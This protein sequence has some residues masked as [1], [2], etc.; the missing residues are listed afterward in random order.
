MNEVRLRGGGLPFQGPEVRQ[1]FLHGHQERATCLADGRAYHDPGAALAYLSLMT[2]TT[3]GYGDVTPAWPGAGGLAAAEAIVG[4]LY[5]A[6]TIARLVGLH[7]G[8]DRRIARDLSRAK[9]DR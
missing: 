8:D 5:L 4:Q 7:S 2:L 6:I 3:V 1:P 9:R